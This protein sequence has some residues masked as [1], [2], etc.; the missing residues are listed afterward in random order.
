M[1]EQ[2]TASLK[3]ATNAFTRGLPQDAQRKYAQ[4]VGDALAQLPPPA[5]NDA[6]TEMATRTGWIRTLRTSQDALLAAAA[7]GHA[8]ASDHGHRARR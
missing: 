5:L 8:P 7:A 2:L 1:P 3:A 4:G 6:L